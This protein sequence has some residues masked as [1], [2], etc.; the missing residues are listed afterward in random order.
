[1]K[2]LLF[3]MMLLFCAAG[4]INAQVCKIS[5]TNDNIEVFSASL[6]N[7]K[8]VKVVVSNDS[9]EISANVTVTIEVTY[10]DGYNSPKT[11]TFTGK[12]LARPNTS[13]E[14][15]IDIPEDIDYSKKPKSVQVTGISGTKCID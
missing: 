12:G 9:Q 8:Q 1:M 15:V 11:K 5:N 7:S 3:I 13:T 6:I 14:I 4:N 2:Q 10:T